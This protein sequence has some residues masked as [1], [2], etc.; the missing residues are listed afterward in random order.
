MLKQLYHNLIYPNLTYGVMS[1]GMT[2]STNLTKIHTKQNKCIRSIF[3]A[4]C[5]ESAAIYYKLLGILDFDCIIEFKI[6]TF[7]KKLS[8]DPTKYPHVFHEYLKPITS[9]HNHNTRLA[10]SDGFYRPNVKTNY[11]QFTIAKLWNSVPIDLK[12]IEFE[13]KAFQTSYKQ[14]LLSFL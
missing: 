3:F 2:Y 6:V 5:M 1:W 11:G 10:A 14:F 7:A 8:N 13:L 4:N 9:V 12:T